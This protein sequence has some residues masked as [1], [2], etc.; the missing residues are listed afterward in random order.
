MTP[1]KKKVRTKRV[2]EMN[3]I[4]QDLYPKAKIA[5]NYTTDF[6]CLVAVQLSAQCTDARVN[7]VTEE[8]F[9]RY[10]TVNDYANA[11]QSDMEKAVYQTGF[12]RNKAK[13]LIA[14]AKKV[15][16]EFDGELPRTLSEM[17]TIPGAARKTA[18]V[19][20]STLYGITEGI[21]VDTHVR[22]F[23]IRFDL[24]EYT[25]PIRIERDLM[26]IMPQELWWGF[27]HRLVNYGRDYCSAHRHDCTVHPL[28]KVYPKATNIWPSAR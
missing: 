9:K 20:L 18:N 10:K 11:S 17:I 14:A 5:L 12:Y 16:D 6:E 8:L 27:N 7:I 2:K 28:T 22:R 23:V 21:A 1:Y 13:N 25:D 24:S 4:L 19:V 3:E 26:D 15:R